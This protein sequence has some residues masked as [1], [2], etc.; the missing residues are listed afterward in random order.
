MDIKPGTV[1][2]GENLVYPKISNSSPD[3]NLS[4]IKN[5]HYFEPR[6]YDNI[7]RWPPCPGPPK[8]VIV[9]ALIKEAPHIKSNPVLTKEFKYLDRFLG[10]CFKGMSH[11]TLNISTSEDL[12]N[13]YGKIGLSYKT[14]LIYFYNQLD[15]L[16]ESHFINKYYISLKD[17]EKSIELINS[18]IK[19]V[20]DIKIPVNPRGPYYAYIKKGPVYGKPEDLRYGY[21]DGTRVYIDDN[22]INKLDKK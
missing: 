19:L 15:F 12:V 17:T 5:Y 9:D 4:N 3:I 6:S 7:Q 11:K 1:R 10:V 8:P 18:Y 22:L 20:D 13:F 16:L 2:K 21:T 14:S